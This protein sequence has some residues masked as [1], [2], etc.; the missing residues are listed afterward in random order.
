MKRKRKVKSLDSLKRQI[1]IK[2]TLLRKRD[3]RENLR[4]LKNKLS[5]FLVTSNLKMNYSKAKDKMI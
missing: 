5:N 4:K 3:R 1:S 2:M